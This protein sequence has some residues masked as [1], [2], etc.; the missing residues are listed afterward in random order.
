MDS[1]L[2][3]YDGGA[4]GLF[5]SDPVVNPMFANATKAYVRYCVSAA[6]SLRR[7]LCA[8]LP[9]PLPPRPSTTDLQQTPYA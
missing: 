2:A 6:L 8:S 4:H 7:S 9:T 1:I 5:S 3:G